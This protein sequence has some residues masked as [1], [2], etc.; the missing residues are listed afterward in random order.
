MQASGRPSTVVKETHFCWGD[1]HNGPSTVSCRLEM[2]AV[3][4]L[5]R[6]S[7]VFDAMGYREMAADT[8]WTFA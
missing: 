2:R 5:L 4:S 3:P 6:T 8:S 1:L 7:F